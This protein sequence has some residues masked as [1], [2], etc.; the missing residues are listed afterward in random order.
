VE[1]EPSVIP[2][3]IVGLERVLRGKQIRPKHDPDVVENDLKG[4]GRYARGGRRI[5]VIREVNT[6]KTG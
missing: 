2:E 5:D 4:N 6:P 1:E 3:L